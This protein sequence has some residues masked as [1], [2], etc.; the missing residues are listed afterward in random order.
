M[1][2]GA[3]EGNIVGSAAALLN[4]IEGNVNSLKSDIRCLKSELKKFK[5]VSCEPSEEVKI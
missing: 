4:E 1:K 5:S 3:K 2:N